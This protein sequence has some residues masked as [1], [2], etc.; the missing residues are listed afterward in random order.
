MKKRL[1]GLVMISIPW[2][3]P[4]AQ[5]LP[6]ALK[7][8][9]T[10]NSPSQ[11]IS[12]V[13]DNYNYL[14]SSEDS[15]LR[16]AEK[17]ADRW[18]YNHAYQLNVQNDSTFSANGYAKAL[19]QFSESP[20]YCNSS[21]LS[22][23]SNIGPRYMQEGQNKQLN[24]QVK[25]IHY[26]PSYPQVIVI[27]TTEAGIFRT[28]NGG[29][30]WTC[31]TDALSMPILG[32]S[33]IIQD[34]F[35]DQ[36]L[37]AVTGVSSGI[38]PI[39]H[40]LLRSNDMGQTWTYIDGPTWTNDQFTWIAPDKTVAG[41]VYA[42]MSENV[43]YSNDYGGTWHNL[44]IPSDL[45]ATNSANLDIRHLRRVRLAGNYLYITNYE[46]NWA[47]LWRG[48][49]TTN[50][51][52]VSVAWSNNIGSQ[53]APPGINVI[54]QPGQ[55]P[56]NILTADFPF[57]SNDIL[58]YKEYTS[59]V[60]CQ[61]STSASYN[62]PYFDKN[63]PNDPNNN[64]NMFGS[65]NRIKTDGWLKE[66][67]QPEPLE[68]LTC[69]NS[70][71]HN[72]VVGNETYDIEVVTMSAAANIQLLYDDANRSAVLEGELPPGVNLKV[73]YSP[74]SLTSPY[75]LTE[76][77]TN[78]ICNLPDINSPLFDYDL[79]FTNL[80]YESG[81]NT[82]NSVQVFNDQ[83]QFNIL[84]QDKQILLE[85]ASTQ[86][87]IVNGT[88]HLYLE[89]NDDYD[90]T[91]KFIMNRFNFEPMELIPNLV[92]ISNVVDSEDKFY[93]HVRTTERSSFYVTEDNGLNF[94][95]IYNDQDDS[96]CSWR[97]EELL[98]SPNFSNTLYRANVNGPFKYTV[99]NNT[100]TATQGITGNGNHDDHRSAFISSV[101]GQDYVL[102]GNDGGISEMYYD[103][104][105]TPSTN[106][107]N[108]DL[109]ISM[110]Y[111]L[112][113][114]EKTNEVLIG[115]QDNATKRFFPNVNNWT[116]VADYDG[117]VTKIRNDIPN[118]YVSGDP[119]FSNQNVLHDSPDGDQS[120]IV[121]D[122]IQMVKGEAF[123]GM[124]LTENRFDESKFVCGLNGTD[125]TGKV[126]VNTGANTEIKSNVTG[127]K[128]ILAVDICQ[129]QP[130]IMYAGEGTFRGQ[131]YTK[132]YKSTDGGINWS[133]VTSLVS[134]DGGS[135]YS[136]LYT[137]KHWDFVN[138]LGV[139]PVSPDLVYMAMSGIELDVNN[140]P[141]DEYFRILRSDQG[142]QTFIDWSEG[143]PAL[144]VRYILPVESSNHLVFAAID[145]GVYYRTDDTDQWECFS[146]NLPKCRVTDLEYNY[147][148]KELYAST[149][150]RGVWRTPVDIYLG[151][152]V[153]N[154]ITSS[155]TWNSPV[156]SKDNIVIKSGNTLYVNA[157]LYMEAD[158]KIIV[159][160]NA[161]LVVQN[162]AIITSNCG[163]FW[164]GIEVWGNSSLPQQF[165]NQGMVTLSGGASIQNAKNA[166]RVWKPN[167]WN[168]MGGIVQADKAS[169][170]NNKRDVEFM[171]YSTQ[172]S[173]ST[174]DNISYFSEC[175]FETNN[176]YLGET[177]SPHVSMYKVEGVRFEACDFLDS[178]NVDISLKE[179]GIH[180][181]D[182]KFS[183]TGK[184]IG[185]TSAQVDYYDD[186]LFDPST[187]TNLTH[188]VWSGLATT[189]FAFTVDQC[190]FTDCEYGV[191]LSNSN[192]GVVTRNYFNRTEGS[193]W[194][195][196]QYDIYTDESTA[197]TIQGN[198]IEKEPDADPVIGVMNENSGH[199][200]NEVRRNII[201]FV[202]HGVYSYGKNKND[203]TG[204]LSAG[205]EY[206]CNTYYENLTQDQLFVEINS[207]DGVKTN[208][209][210]PSSPAGNVFTSGSGGFLNINS[211]LST[212]T[213]YHYYSNAPFNNQYPASVTSNVPLYATTTENG[214]RSI[215]EKINPGG[216]GEGEGKAFF[217][218]PNTTSSLTTEFNHLQ[219]TLTK[220]VQD[221]SNEK[222]AERIESLE[223]EILWLKR[224]M[225]RLE[226][227][228]IKDALLSDAS[229]NSDQLVEWTEK[230]DGMYTHQQLSDFYWSQNDL[231]QWDQHLKS[232]QMIGEEMLE[233]DLK[234]EYLDFESFKR[235]L[236]TFTNENSIIEGLNS[237][238]EVFLRSEA[239]SKT[240]IAQKQAENLLCFF[241]GECP[242]APLP[243][244]SEGEATKNE[245][246]ENVME[247]EESDNLSI[248]P[249]PSV[250]E[251][252][253]SLDTDALPMTIQILD[254]TGKE[255]IYIESYQNDR[256]IDISEYESGVY[257][258]LVQDQAGKQ[259]M[260]RLIK[261]KL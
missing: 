48:T 86:T 186:L 218:S 254:P 253:I 83:V 171:P 190:S 119:Q 98:V 198:I 191:V 41:R 261:G 247:M 182:S 2:I 229:V 161:R 226:N 238:A 68:R 30:N 78:M 214:C 192:N 152:S 114:N 211:Q 90:P 81:F 56:A 204:H 53:L 52:N 147:C 157:N 66:V 256:L 12:D 127:S 176:S 221:L 235:S 140:D 213:R 11:S 59:T 73:Y 45:Y 165:I 138:A 38:D 230:K 28:T 35:N 25:A 124:R 200:N 101:N 15:T 96:D 193:E 34:N 4:H 159:E 51:S 54:L 241:L 232:V 215:F 50:G 143:L 62:Y 154:E 164:D 37:Y 195:S 5:E 206:L 141:I 33:Q 137:M 110:I 43:A 245:T 84:G 225:N 128:K 47:G 153:N 18:F 87:G 242:Q 199:D 129:R 27:G 172:G 118:Y 133:P 125:G 223:Y 201:Q 179:K 75:G 107:L 209:G 246:S 202:D 91:T 20:F 29:Q 26:N 106:S 158:R 177:V 249:N 111:N 208:Q 1:I 183:V 239:T 70:E 57:V 122:N 36:I 32:C 185:T 250:T 112:D 79:L 234:Q 31:V 82:T 236:A 3:S 151:T 77:N 93:I 168:S 134:F 10:I 108:G 6:D 64:Q 109:S 135:T 170:I 194:F 22:D 85:N 145:G 219:E 217:K 181:L 76:H 189:Q 173:G 65:W 17:K 21:D 136:D 92:A 123:L 132:L 162:G 94:T 89:F 197:Y 72:K 166:I 39:Q 63:N 42:V 257:F 8:K 49:I 117:T 95:E 97:N 156:E 144:P 120:G 149:F 121:N 130:N 74:Y 40:G 260:K 58:D 255:L 9:Q 224:E 233:G 61:Y 243:I 216:S 148:T 88:V 67:V 180:A 228:L 105:S 203:L 100:I 150:G 237:D 102:W 251:I 13:M 116:H 240:G 80:V 196:Y 175:Q 227:L 187:F 23:W 169:F 167:D 113:I 16:K 160:P 7:K 44:G 252:R 24:G 55:V 231:E 71:T 207:G 104:V 205:L 19:K 163:Q 178:R 46:N 259:H 60:G 184:F 115:L 258:V 222:E 220:K 212:S 146:N 103:G 244:I 14:K 126:L 69:V 174:Q 188:G 139:D 210:K 142:G 155:T 131:D 248:S 99:T